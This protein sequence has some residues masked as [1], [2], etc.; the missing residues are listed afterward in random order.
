MKA[1]RL[2]ASAILLT[3]L[4]A[5]AWPS[6]IDS[7]SY[8][9]QFRDYPNAPASRQFPLG[10][11][12]LGRDRL[13]RLLYATR[14][15]LL[16]APAAALLSTLLAAFAGGLAG[17]LGDPY[18]RAT[19]VVI[20]LMLSLPWLFLMILVRALLPLNVPGRLSLLV[21]FGLIGLLGWPS[22]ARVV[23][24]GCREL[25]RSD[26]VLQATASG[27][28]PTRILLVHVL[29][30]TRPILL[31][32]FWASIPIYILAEANLGILGLGVSDPLPSW[33]N[34]LRPLETAFAAPAEAWAPLA[35]MLVVVG[36]L[37]LTK[38]AEAL[39]R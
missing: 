29:P 8:D 10:T 23:R 13:S 31:A 11:D 26:M 4:L 27:I 2:I 22:A 39:A 28:R 32:Q 7:A 5:A 21:T 1:V 24:A 36:C 38:P 25:R 15:S 30:N 9:R 37:Y 19:G 16:A 18:D 20:D 14:I 35:L 34:L 17:F 6:A 33:G 12:E 3:V